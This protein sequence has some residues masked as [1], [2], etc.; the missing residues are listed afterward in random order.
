MIDSYSFGK[1]SI[2]GKTYRSD[3]IIFPDRVQDSWWRKEGHNLCLLDIQDII[4]FSPE[5]LIIGQGSPGYMQVPENV[6]TD[7]LSRG[8]ELFISETGGAVRK[9]NETFGLR[10]TVAALHLT[11]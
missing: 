4:S 5:V 3:V 9:Y 10:K 7:I 1:I 11:C 6:Q 2:D 8:I